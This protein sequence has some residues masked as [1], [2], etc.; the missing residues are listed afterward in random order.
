MIE[1]LLSMEVDMFIAR[2]RK[3]T[4]NSIADASLKMEGDR[5]EA[6]RDVA[7]TGISAAQVNLNKTM[8]YSYMVNS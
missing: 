1:I 8:I 7:T 4:M 5:H 2:K 6:A 3:E